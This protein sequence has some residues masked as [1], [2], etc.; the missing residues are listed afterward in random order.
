MEIR[1]TV[2]GIGSSPRKGGNSDVLLK[3]VL[4]GVRSEGVPAR[5]IQLRDYHYLPCIGCEKCQNSARCSGLNDGMQ[6]IYPKLLEARGLV[7]VSPTH[8]L[9]VTAW[10]KAFIDRLYCLYR[11]TRDRPRQYTSSL[12]GQGRKMVLVAIGE[13]PGYEEAIGLTLDAMKIPFEFL[14]YELVGEL[15]VTGIFDKGAVRSDSGV[16][17]KARSIGTQLAQTIAYQV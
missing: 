6:L 5:E 14:G 1:N 10:M 3:Q 2:L 8:N 17:E 13:Q 7:L 11:F 4:T 12:A 16:M 9:N 15:P